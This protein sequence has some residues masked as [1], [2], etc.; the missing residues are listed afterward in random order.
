MKN[1]SS[2]CSVNI[3]KVPS[4]LRKHF[5]ALCKLRGTNMTKAIIE[6]M[7]KACT[8]RKV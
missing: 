2:V 3:R 4:E 5:Q 8:E 1:K 6:Y 7:R